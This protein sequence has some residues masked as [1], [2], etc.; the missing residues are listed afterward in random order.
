MTRELVFLLSCYLTNS[1]ANSTMVSANPCLTGSSVISEKDDLKFVRDS[2]QSQF[3]PATVESD[4]SLIIEHIA[5]SMDEAI[6]PDV[7]WEEL[8]TIY[9][10]KIDLNN[11]EKEDLEL[12]F[13]LSDQQIEEILYFRYQ[14]RGFTSLYDLQLVKGMDMTDIRNLLPF[15]EVGVYKAYSRS[16]I[17]SLK[18]AKHEV[19]TQFDRV[20]NSKSGYDA[21]EDGSSKYVGNPW[22][23]YLKYNLK[24]EDK[25]FIN[26]SFEKDA[27]EYA[28]FK[29]L[30]TYDFIS[31]SVLV[32]PRK[33]IEQFVVGDYLL[34]FGQGLAMNQLFGRGK[35]GS[36]SQTF[37]R[38][39]GIRK[40]SSL[41]E[42]NFLRGAAFNLKRNKK[43]LTLFVSSRLAD[44]DSS[45]ASISS[46]YLT[47]YHRT[48]HE[49]SK[50]N[51][52]R[53]SLLG[54]DTNES[55]S[56]MQVGLLSYYMHYSLPFVKGEKEY[57]L[58]N[59]EGSGQWVSSLYYRAIAG[60]IHLFG[61]GSISDF[62]HLAFLSGLL[63]RLDSQTDL[64]LIYRNYSPAYSTIFSNAF[65]EGG[66][67][68]NERGLY[69]ALKYDG[70]KN[71]IFNA[72]ADT[73]SFPWLRYNT[74]G[75]SN[76]SDLYFNAGFSGWRSM[77]IN[78]RVKTESYLS[79]TK[80][81]L[82]IDQNWEDRF[83]RTKSG[84]DINFIQN[85]EE[86][87][88]GWTL[89]QDLGFDLWKSKVKMDF[90]YV[91]FHSDSYDNRIYL[92]EKDL[93][94]NFSISALSGTGYRMYALFAIHLS[95]HNKLW[96][97]LSKTIYTDQ[98]EV[99]GSGKERIQ[100]NTKS[101][102]K[103]EYQLKL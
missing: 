85:D 99:I 5:E 22:H 59:F 96:L 60:P 32:K 7:Y 17:N 80:S 71:W 62:Q 74:D 45:G 70:I 42:N 30:K 68:N 95:K 48:S 52:F 20:L 92:Y 101:D 49:L 57:Q 16:W 90:R 2:V 53:Q 73:Y 65:R 77:R 82:K 6:E 51:S 88:K 23:H 55:F 66:K 13:F 38:T 46:L 29:P 58:Y 19:L 12:L 40:Y 27:G 84:F 76:G 1:L 69:F 63:Y 83:V 18:F 4:L 64:T 3:L 78:F 39:Q 94:R 97:K 103:I 26:F 11:C 44:A 10:N 50:K 54:F 36:L 28:G 75:P 72:Y 15:I 8:Q 86:L 34:G 41:N 81:A 33:L 9:E 102:F 25:L 91:V 14:N 93:Y 35:V 56:K 24:A 87:N 37:T 79:A 98:R 21:G 67:V 43:N 61:E 31:V 100:G 89:F 47:G